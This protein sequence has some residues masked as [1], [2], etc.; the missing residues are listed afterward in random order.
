MNRIIPG[1]A[2]KGKAPITPHRG[3]NVGRRRCATH[4]G[5]MTPS[6]LRRGPLD[7]ARHRCHPTSSQR[8]QTPPSRN[9]RSSRNRTCRTNDP[10]R[11]RVPR[12]NRRPRPS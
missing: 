7:A 4:L 6:S 8:E 11:R 2:G 5:A 3:T 12:G 9:H 1:F 10:S